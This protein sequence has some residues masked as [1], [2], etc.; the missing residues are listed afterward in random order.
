[1]GVAITKYHRL[2]DLND[3]HLILMI[4]GARKFKTK[5]LS[6]SVVGESPFPGV[7]RAMTKLCGHVNLV[8]I[9]LKPSN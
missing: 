5:V 3:R 2:A 6:D 1:M 7:L 8:F 9:F 4:P